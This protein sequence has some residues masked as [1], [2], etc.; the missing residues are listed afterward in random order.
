MD[1]II[2]KA[3]SFIKEKGSDIIP[4]I[5]NDNYINQDTIDISSLMI[6]YIKE[7]IVCQNMEKILLYLEDQYILTS[8][9]NLYRSSFGS[10]R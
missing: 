5:Y 10:R 7:K 9:Y 6:N 3:K 1:D 4:K 8:L 2:E